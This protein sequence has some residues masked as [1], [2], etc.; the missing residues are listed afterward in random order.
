MP[1]A[2]DYGRL[3][4]WPGR[5]VWR[6]SVDVVVLRCDGCVLDAC[7]VAVR[8][9][10]RSTKLPRV[11][12]IMEGGNDDEAGGGG[13]G[14]GS[15][16]KNDLAVDGDVRRASSPEGADGCPLVVTVSV[17]TES[18]SS[19]PSKRQRSVAVV[20]ARAE[21]EACASSRVCVSVDPDGMVCGVHTLGGNAGPD[22]EGGASSSSSSMPL[23]MLGDIVTSAA[24]AS[25]NLYALLDGN[26]GKA[27][28]TSVAGDDGGCGYGYLLKDSFLI[29]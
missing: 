21:E 9:A 5:Y 4:V 11:R 22:E 1:H 28:P 24:I 2:V 14:G 8:E 17:L 23:S 15:S 19:A 20:D 13:G 27:G 16:R 3:A 10:L 12:A 7:S 26:D 29:Q 25:K 18:V 6:L